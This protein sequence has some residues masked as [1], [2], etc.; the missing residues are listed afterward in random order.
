MGLPAFKNDASGYVSPEDYL[1]LEREAAHKHEY[2][3]GEIRAMAGA[4]S[5][6]N[7]L[8][9]NLSGLLFAQLDGSPCEGYTSDQRVQVFNASSYLYPD[10]SVVCDGAEFNTAKNPEN[11]LNPTL[12]VEVLSATTAGADRGEKFMLYR[13]LPSL[14]QYLMLD[15]QTIHAE[16]YTRQDDDHWLFGE[17]RDPAAVLDLRS[18]GAT[19]PLA[20]LYRGVPLE[21]QG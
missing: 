5:A 17:T 8:C 13:Q 14:R 15:S 10:L 4:K 12:I 19:L 6:H 3:A 1:R 7:R 18:V 2:Y 9:F 20:S 16:L 21:S 11:L